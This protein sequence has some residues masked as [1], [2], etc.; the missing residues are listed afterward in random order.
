MTRWKGTGIKGLI[1][2]LQRSALIHYLALNLEVDLAGSNLSQDQMLLFKQIL[3]GNQ[4]KIFLILNLIVSP[5]RLP[6]NF[7]GEQ[8]QYG[9]K[10]IFTDTF[11]HQVLHTS[12]TLQH[13]GGGEQKTSPLLGTI[14]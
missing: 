14:Y 6:K 9:E 3:L 13:P 5:L 7:S 12:T 8:Q 11:N 1:A 10:A 2:P 4:F